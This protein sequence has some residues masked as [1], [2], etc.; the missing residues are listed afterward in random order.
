MIRALF[1]LAIALATACGGSKPQCA[2][3]APSIPGPAFLWKVQK[4][5]DVVWLFGTIHNT[6]L[7]AVPASAKDALAKSPRLVT[8]L[9]DV[10]VDTDMFRK[11]ARNASGKGIDQ[12]LPADDWWDLRDALLGKVKEDDLRRMR[13]WYAMS[14]LT[15]FLAPSQ[16]PSMDVELA[17]RAE[18]LSIPVE[19][20]ESWEDQLWMLDRTVGVADLQEA[21]RARKTMRCDLAR[22]ENAYRAGDI[23]VMQ[24]LLVV[25]R[26]K[27]V[28]LT[29]RNKKWFPALEKQFGQGGA[30]VAVGLG[31]L[32]GDDG[33]VAMLQRAGYTVERIA[34]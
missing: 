14:Q 4:G 34:Q 25:P 22:L 6:G 17:E 15:K 3:V 2:V 16:G 19:P 32:L 1:A 30:F 21:I 12:L 23:V 26:T 13:P 31:H 8:E 9:G 20:L 11:Y 29:A 10:D 18:K 28:M 7:D 24:A 27:D 5:G 33:L